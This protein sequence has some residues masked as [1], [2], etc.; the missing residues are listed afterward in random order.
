MSLTG[1]RIVNTR[2]Q[3]QAGSLDT[4]LHNY[5]ATP[6]RYPCIAIV[7]PD[8][9]RELDAALQSEFN[10][11]VLTSANTVMIL[12]EELQRLGLTLSGA[13]AAAVGSATADAAREW[14]GVDVTTIPDDFSADGLADALTITPGQRILLPQSAVARPALRDAL[15]ARGA[16]V[17]AVTAYQ[18][19]RGRGGVQLLPLLRARQVDAISF[20]SSSTAR[21]FTERLAAEGGAVDDLAGVTIACIGEQTRHSAEALGLTVAVAPAIHTLDGMIEAL[22]AYFQEQS[23]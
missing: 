4:V 15:S 19:V 7:P 10:L 21:Y 9:T 17:I 20:T 13:T 23:T 2:A 12:E 8:D 3:H 1:R 6:I 11:L 16:D 22:G 18:T 5:G 14:L